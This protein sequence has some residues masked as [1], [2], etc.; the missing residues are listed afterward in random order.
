[1]IDIDYYR[2]LAIIGLSINYVWIST[3]PYIF[4]NT[5][6]RLDRVRVFNKF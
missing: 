1:M 6:N 3:Y 4:R 5:I 2:L